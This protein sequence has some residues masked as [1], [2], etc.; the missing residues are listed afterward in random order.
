MR[1]LLL[2]G[3]RIWHDYLMGVLGLIAVYRRSGKESKNRMAMRAPPRVR[4]RLHRP[5]C[6]LRLFP[7]QDT[8]EIRQLKDGQTR[9]WP[10]QDTHEI[11]QLKEQI[12]T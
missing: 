5:S 2:D 7:N 8:H 9:T 6:S 1:P 4:S 3:G 12:G 10:N 11:R